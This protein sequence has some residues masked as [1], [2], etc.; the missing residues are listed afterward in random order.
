M[1]LPKEIEDQY[2]KEVI[3]NNSL[4]NLPNE[5]WKL[6]EGFENY[7]IS[8]YGRVKSLKRI[9]VTPR[10]RREEP[11]KV[12]ELFF[13][14]YSNKYLERSYYNTFCSLSSEGV[15][16][17]KSIARLVYYHFIE[18]YDMDNKSVVISYKD[19]NSFHLHYSNLELLSISEQRY[20]MFRKN[21][22]RSWKSDYQ[23]PISQYTINGDFVASFNSIYAADKA[24]GIAS[25]GILY[26][27][28]RKNFT[29]GGFRWFYKEYQP[30]KEDFIFTSKNRTRSARTNDVLNINLWMRL[31]KP[32]IDEN[33]P[34]ACMNLS[35]NDFPGEN[36][37]PVP[38][39][40]KTYLVSNKGRVKRLSGWIV[41]KSKTYMGEQIMRLKFEVKPNNKDIV[42]FSVSLRNDKKGVQITLNRLLY[43]CFVKPF[44]LND[45]TIVINNQSQPMWNIELS[46]LSLCSLSSVLKGKNKIRPK[47]KQG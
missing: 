15:K 19:S 3:Y 46:K 23:Q 25:G 34:P 18:K 38:D 20:K 45:K 41:G 14:K 12:M 4:N 40:E 10:S 42:R 29:A 21:R 11:E 27:L 44:D 5:E 26:V 39:F 16:Y 17:R 32:L 37:K 35:L 30:E 22:A 7:E 1:K 2:L 13:T 28:Q 9:T 31:G 6:I 43:Y 8:N 33:N 47:K 36:W 24:L